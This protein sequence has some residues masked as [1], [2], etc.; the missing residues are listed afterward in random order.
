M[1]W[2]WLGYG[3]SEK[4]YTTQDLV[5]AAEKYDVVKV[6]EI[7]KAIE[8]SPDKM[9]II[10]GG[11]RTAFQIVFS[12]VSKIGDW[13]FSTSDREVSKKRSCIE[14][15]ILLI[16]AGANREINSFDD[17]YLL[18][19]SIKNGHVHLVNALF[20]AGLTLN[21]D[22]PYL[23][24][25]GDKQSSELLALLLKNGARVNATSR[26]GTSALHVACMHGN[27]GCIDV[28]LKEPD[29]DLNLLDNNFNRP[30]DYLSQA[31]S[32]HILGRG[33]IED[34]IR[35]L[36]DKGAVFTTQEERNAAEAAEEQ[37]RERKE[38]EGKGDERP[39]ANKMRK[40]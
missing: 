11:P 9:K 5:K 30:L 19:W 29:I 20:D 15:L 38:P 13:N 26:F 17:D 36:R 7:L 10:D 18:E 34:Y 1:L 31:A 27:T 21:D 24:L 39:S 28:L 4:V 32:R 25:P 22:I 33:G 6:Q 3:D 23:V 8:S 14:I 35:K 40:I 2:A 12:T 16:K 37:K